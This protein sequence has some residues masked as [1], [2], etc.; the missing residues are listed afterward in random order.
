MLNNQGSWI[1]RWVEDRQVVKEMEQMPIGGLC[2][3]G[4]CVFSVQLFQLLCILENFHS[5]VLEQMRGFVH[6]LFSFQFLKISRKSHVSVALTLHFGSEPV[7][8]CI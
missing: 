7:A 4:T 3:I 8:G 1:E 6:S 5:T 2:M